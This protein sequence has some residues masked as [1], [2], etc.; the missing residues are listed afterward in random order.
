MVFMGVV[1]LALTIMSQFTPTPQL[2]LYE[3]TAN[4]RQEYIKGYIK[5][6][7]SSVK[8]DREQAEFE[9]FAMCKI[10]G[11]LCHDDP[12]KVTTADQSNSSVG[13]VIS[14]FTFPLLNMPASGIGSVQSTIAQAGLV[15][16]AL[17][18]DGSGFGGLAPYGFLWEQIRN[19]VYIVLVLGILFA[20]FALMFRSAL[21]SAS[22]VAIEN[23]LPKI[24][25]TMI[26]IQLSFAIAGFLIDAM[27]VVSGLIVSIFGPLIFPKKSIYEL[28]NM[29]LFTSPASIASTLIGPAGIVGGFWTIM[30]T[31]PDSLMSIFGWQAR[32]IFEVIMMV[33][34]LKYIKPIIDASHANG[35]TMKDYIG[36]FL[37]EIY[38]LVKASAGGPIRLVTQIALDAVSHLVKYLFE[39][40]LVLIFMFFPQFVIGLMLFFALLVAA[41]KIFGMMF[42]AYIR[43]LLYVIFAPFIL[44]LDLMPGKSGFKQWI[45]SILGELAVFPIFIAISMV[46]FLIMS[47]ETSGIGLR[48]PY[49]IGVEPKAFSYLIGVAILAMSPGFIDKFRK[50]VFGSGIDLAGDAKNALLQGLPWITNKRFPIPGNIPAAYRRVQDVVTGKDVKTEDQL[51]FDAIKKA[52]TTTP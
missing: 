52:R 48:L 4:E 43:I 34:A 35:T 11:Q 31:L 22:A 18:A 49:L 13:K 16:Q 46:S 50:S 36:N 5:L 10:S 39:Y 44:M 33:V 37:L 20:G 8:A 17:A 19:V 21:N 1:I 30:Y 38:K 51:I 15:P 23:M 7:E 6:K 40:G 25:I 41:W 27:Y 14:I 24:I 12:F 26:L 45:M 42:M 47:Y 32:A 9:K 28:I 29:Y 2:S 3:K